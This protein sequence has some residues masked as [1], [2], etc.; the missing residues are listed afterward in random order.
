MS[1]M[2]VVSLGA[3]FST[4]NLGVGAL[5]AGT[6]RAVLH[7]FPA[8]QLWLLDYGKESLVHQVRDTNRVVAVPLLNIRFSKKLFLKNN[9][10]RLLLTVLAVRLIPSARLRKQCHAGDP[11]LQPLLDADFVTSIAGGDSFSDIYGMRRLLYVALP[12]ILALWLG[13]PLVL[14]PQTYGPF[15]SRTARGLARYILRRSRLIFSRDEAGLR[16]VKDLT[17]EQARPARFAY[18]MGFAL[19]PFPPEPGVI[20]ELRQAVGSAPLVG[21][22]V[23]GLLYSGGYTGDNMF[24]LKADY[25]EMIYALLRCLITERQAQV[26]LVPHV[27]GTDSESDI[28]ACEA[29]LGA[30]GA[31]FKGRLHFFRREFDQHEV[32]YLIGQCDFFLGSRMHACIAALS[33]CV[34]AIGLAYSR[35][36]AGV[37]DSIGGGATVVDLRQRET[38]EV[39][40]IVGPAFDQRKDLRRELEKRMTKI[41][42]AALNLFGDPEFGDILSA[43]GSI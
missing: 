35:K 23:S 9:I 4:N 29:V 11:V 40:R 2:K 3:G 16:V 7:Q 5:A 21:L 19:E 20:Q 10:A 26:L 6:A 37:L 43:R 38:A 33:Q 41:K 27:L 32:K 18:D 31:E 30:H 14:L 36:F 39:V 12:Q 34:P 28:T 17:G 15:K 42:K 1:G 25:K 13:K 22:N 24:G 8:G